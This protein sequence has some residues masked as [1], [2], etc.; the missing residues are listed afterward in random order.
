VQEI[1][2]VLSMSIVDV[3]NNSSGA[4]VGNGVNVRYRTFP[5]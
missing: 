1:Q 3:E 2:Q 4:I 5:N